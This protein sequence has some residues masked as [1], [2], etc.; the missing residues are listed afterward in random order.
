MLVPDGSNASGPT[1]RGLFRL[2]QGKLASFRTMGPAG[3]TG[4]LADSWP[5]R[6]VRELALFCRGLL[7]AQFAITLS[8]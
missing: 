4:S 6:S 1:R 7:R 8:S 3:G 2:V 5:S